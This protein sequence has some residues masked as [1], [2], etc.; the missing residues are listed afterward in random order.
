M[1]NIAKALYKF[2]PDRS[3]EELPKPPCCKP[4]VQMILKTG[5]K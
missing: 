4:A 2:N 3:F 5:T 1:T